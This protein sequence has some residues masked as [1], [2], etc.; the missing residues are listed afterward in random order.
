MVGML[1]HSGGR[2]RGGQNNQA[3]FNW[4]QAW[5]IYF[6]FTVTITYDECIA[7][8]KNSIGGS[9]ELSGLR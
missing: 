2:Q 8:I 9:L 6:S 5:Q 1:L 3:D 4:Q 7:G